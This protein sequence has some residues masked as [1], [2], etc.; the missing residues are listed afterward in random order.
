LE[1]LDL[2]PQTLVIGFGQ[3]PQA[4]KGNAAQA[5]TALGGSTHRPH[6]VGITLASLIPK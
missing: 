1:A 5:L 4:F 3:G 6:K 2:G